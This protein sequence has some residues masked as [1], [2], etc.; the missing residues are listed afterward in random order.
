MAEMNVQQRKEFVVDEERVVEESRQ[1]AIS[2]ILKTSKARA[3]EEDAILVKGELILEKRNNP[4]SFSVQIAEVETSKTQAAMKSRLV[5]GIMKTLAAISMSNL[6]FV[7]EE[8][9]WDALRNAMTVC[10]LQKETCF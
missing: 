8:A 4:P 10:F 7:S 9:G 6:R 3:V 2:M 1:A 5:V